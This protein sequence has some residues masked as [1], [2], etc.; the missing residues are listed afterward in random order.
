MN[1]YHRI[2]AVSQKRSRKS[3]KDTQSQNPNNRSFECFHNK[4]IPDI[5]PWIVQG[6]DD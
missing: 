4:K 1:Q 3:D 6:D 2:R 5:N